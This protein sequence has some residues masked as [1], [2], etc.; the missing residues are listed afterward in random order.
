MSGSRS[1]LHG[2]TDKGS[3]SARRQS[4]RWFGRQASSKVSA[5]SGRAPFPAIYRPKVEPWSPLIERRH[6]GGSRLERNLASRRFA[7]RWRC[8]DRAVRGAWRRLDELRDDR[9]RVDR[10]CAPG[11]QLRRQRPC[12]K[13]ERLELWNSSRCAAV[14][15][16]PTE[17]AHPIVNINKYGRV[18]IQSD[19]LLRD[20]SMTGSSGVPSCAVSV[21]HGVRP[22]R[23]HDAEHLVLEFGGPD[24]RAVLEIDRAKACVG[25]STFNWR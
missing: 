6:R 2:R 17:A 5:F 21:T 4:R 10:M 18:L 19:R 7:R 9:R 13:P 24:G 8:E 1:P 22:K 11:G 12:G 25:A 15:S 20:F 16:W 3:A 14:T 23:D